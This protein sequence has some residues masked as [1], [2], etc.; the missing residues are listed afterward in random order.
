MHKQACTLPDGK[1]YIP[2]SCIFC[3]KPFNE[4]TS[5]SYL[6]GH[7]SC[8]E[9]HEREVDRKMQRELVELLPIGTTF[10]FC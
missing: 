5:G 7:Q 3:T 10:E 6:Y 4:E 8:A 2:G 1:K 9:A